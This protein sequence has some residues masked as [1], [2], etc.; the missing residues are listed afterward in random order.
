[1]KNTYSI[2]AVHNNIIHCGRQNSE[3]SPE[4]PAPGVCAVDNA[5]P[6]GVA[7]ASGWDGLSL[8]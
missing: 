6:S 4:I 1:M 5:V 7:R 3:M 2:G 8:S